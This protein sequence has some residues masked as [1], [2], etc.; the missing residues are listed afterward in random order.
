M[1]PPQVKDKIHYAR[2]QC[3]KRGR[4]THGSSEHLQRHRD[5]EF[6][7]PRIKTSDKWR[8]FSHRVKEE[9][10]AP[11]IKIQHK[12]RRERSRNPDFDMVIKEKER[13]KTN[14]YEKPR[15]GSSIFS[16]LINRVIGRHS[17]PGKSR[18]K[19]NKSSHI[20][21]P[22]VRSKKSRGS[23]PFS[24]DKIGKILK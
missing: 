9:R 5:N 8:R 14:R 24:L 21:A 16:S 23:S 6:E 15:G 2:P 12:P 1:S 7:Y 22:R 3:E 18:K 13:G 10:T 19:R 20:L 11:S 17:S 4:E